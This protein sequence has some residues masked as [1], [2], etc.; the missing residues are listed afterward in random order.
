MQSKQSCPK[1]PLLLKHLSA[2][3]GKIEIQAASPCISVPSGRYGGSS[4]TEAIRLNCI[5]STATSSWEVG[6]LKLPWQ[7]L[8]TGS[9]TMFCSVL[10]L[11]SILHVKNLPGKIRC[12]G[13]NVTG[14]LEVRT[15]LQ[16]ESLCCAAHRIVR[17]PP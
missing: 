9:K 6:L 3:L 2:Y 10:F 4:Y 14:M 1:R 12:P 16:T 13:R 11:F 5:C 17:L 7:P 8:W 15:A